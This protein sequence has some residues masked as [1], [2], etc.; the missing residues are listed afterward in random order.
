[1]DGHVR[2][3][4]RRDDEIA[5]A[6][7]EAHRLA[8]EPHLVGRVLEV[9]PS[10]MPAIG[11]MP[12]RSPLMSMSVGLPKPEMREPARELVDAHHRGE[13][14][15]VDVAGLRD[16]GFHRDHA[17]AVRTPVAEAVAASPAG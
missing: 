10:S 16:R 5:L 13:L 8:G 17:V 7:A 6:D 11:R 2:G 15:E 3:L 4:Q 14:V 12:L 1:M 9:L